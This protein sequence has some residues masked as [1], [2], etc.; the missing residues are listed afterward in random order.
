MAEVVL[1]QR[2]CGWRECGALFFICRSCDRGQRYC[3]G[4]CRAKARREQC[5]QAN[6]RHQQSEE[7]RK[8]HR[9]HQ[10]AYRERKRRGVTDQG[11]QAESS[12]ATLRE[13]LRA[14]FSMPARPR[15]EPSEASHER[16]AVRFPRR[17]GPVCARC[18]RPGRF[19]DPFGGG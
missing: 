18:G 13:M 11:R 3:C 6:R 9:D 5:R 7:G 1:R 8:D 10:R 19:I 12:S 16:I 17:R 4:D 15:R 2:L 14:A